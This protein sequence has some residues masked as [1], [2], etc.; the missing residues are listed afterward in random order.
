[1]MYRIRPFGDSIAAGYG[2]GWGCSFTPPHPQPISCWP[3]NEIGGGYRAFLAGNPPNK[4]H[5]IM[6]GGRHD[7]SAMW[8]WRAGQQNHDGYSGYTISQLFSIAGQKNDADLILV[9][10]GTN[11]IVTG[12]NGEATAAAL[13]QLLITLL[14]KDL[15]AKILVAKIVP[16]YNHGKEAVVRD[17]NSRIPDIVAHFA[18]WGRIVKDVDLHSGMQSSDFVDGVHPNFAGYEKMADRWRVATNALPAL[19]L[20]E[21]PGDGQSSEDA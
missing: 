14:L 4:G 6:M 18:P 1:M 16:I 11:D 5:M 7:N 19:A 15:R 20:D 2:L 13:K 8:M 21:I 12:S 17:Y 3:P 10:A 9:H